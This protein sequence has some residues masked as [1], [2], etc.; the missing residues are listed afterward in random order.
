MNKTTG[1][2]NLEQPKTAASCGQ[3]ELNCYA[4]RETCLCQKPIVYE[5]KCDKCDGRNTTWSEY[6]HMIW[7]FDCEIDTPGTGGIFDGPIPIHT[8]EM[9]GISFDKIR[10][11][12]G[13]ILKMKE[14]RERLTWEEV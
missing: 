2:P 7:C 9:I 8:C 5:V 4:K 6:E 12:D 13:K 11:A 10:L 1:T 3:R 14:G